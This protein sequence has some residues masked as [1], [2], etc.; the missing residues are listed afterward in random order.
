MRAQASAR[1][2][3]NF[4]RVCSVPG[5]DQTMRNSGYCTKHYTK[6][7]RLDAAAKAAVK[8]AALSWLPVNR[9]PWTYE[10]KESELI[11]EQERKN[12]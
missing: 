11:A 5:C 6:W 4:A 1:N 2:L 8:A 10:G 7:S 9:M 12:S 3:R